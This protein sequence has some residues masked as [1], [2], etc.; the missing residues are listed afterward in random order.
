L[1]NGPGAVLRCRSRE[2]GA[3][4]MSRT[5]SIPTVLRMVPNDLLKEFFLRL[6]HSDLGIDWDHAGKKDID[7]FLRP[8]SELRRPVLD[9]VE[10]ALHSVFD[11]ACET[12]ITAWIEAGVQSADLTLATDMPQENGLYHKAMW[13]LL[14]RSEL[15]DKALLIH[16]V[17]N[18][19]WW[20]KRN[21]LP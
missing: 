10:A 6:C 19:S 15:V 21:D 2:K 5:F 9:G 1:V 4:G 11:R 14:N 3:T 20:R 17:E 7:C 18:M 8:I 13:A 16:Q 12:G